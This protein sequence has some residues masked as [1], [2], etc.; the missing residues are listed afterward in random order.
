MESVAPPIEAILSKELRHP[1]VVATLRCARRV[2]GPSGSSYSVSGSVSA[3]IA[4]ARGGLKSG[5]GDKSGCFSDDTALACSGAASGVTR[6]GGSITS[7]HGTSGGAQCIMP[8]QSGESAGPEAGWLSEPM[9][10]RNSAGARGGV[11]ASGSAST[12]SASTGQGG[13]TNSS[14]TASPSTPSEAASVQ[15]SGSCE[16]QQPQGD[17]T[18]DGSARWA[19]IDKPAAE[20]A[21]KDSGYDSDAASE[22]YDT[23]DDVGRDSNMSPFLMPPGSANDP[24]AAARAP[25]ARSGEPVTNSGKPE[26]WDSS[27]HLVRHQTWLLMEY[28][29][30]GC[31]QVRPR[32]ARAALVLLALLACSTGAAPLFIPGLHR[33]PVWPLEPGGFQLLATLG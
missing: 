6:D 29:D 30:R 3:A 24:A 13:A 12:A 18:S 25:G 1:H 9:D 28:C 7:G 22:A 15:P 20:E 21:V 16:G 5:K 26:R 8:K 14:S 23:F 11:N 10:G 19:I 4:A 27:A 32:R 33:A 2:V 17:R 31:L